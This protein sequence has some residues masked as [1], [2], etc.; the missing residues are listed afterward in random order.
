MNPL[1]IVIRGAKY[2]AKGVNSLKKSPKKAPDYIVDKKGVAR[3]PNQ[4]PPAATKQPNPQQ[5]TITV[6]SAGTARKSSYPVATQGSRALTKPVA[7]P[8]SSGVNARSIAGAAVTAGATYLG[9]RDMQE[10]P[11]DPTKVFGSRKGQEAPKTSDNYSKSFTAGSARRSFAA[12]DPRRSDVGG[13]QVVSKSRSAAPAAAT[14]PKPIKQEPPQKTRSAK[15]VTKVASQAN[16][17]PAAKA[18]TET[19][20]VGSG[21]K[22]AGVSIDGGMSERVSKLGEVNSSVMK[23]DL[24]EAGLKKAGLAASNS[25]GFGGSFKRLFEGNIDQKGSEAYNKYG[26]G[27]GLAELAKKKK[28]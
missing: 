11:Y 18:N 4:K 8:K 24:T 20:F 7:A 23:A 25:E 16:A 9:L 14:K 6:D 15:T 27:R 13:R 28:K 19:K 12:T 22:T 17:A 21:L 2:V 5:G 10:T 3:R 1:G 26:A